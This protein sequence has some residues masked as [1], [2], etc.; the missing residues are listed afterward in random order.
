MQYAKGVPIAKGL[1]MQTNLGPSELPITPDGRIYHLNLLPEELADTVITVGDPDRVTMISK[2]F[3]RI[4]VQQQHREFVTH[5]GTLNNKRLSVISTGIG[6]S[7]ID[8]VMNELDA[9]ANIDF[10]TREYK[11]THR[12]LNII[13]IG[14]CG[15]LHDDIALG[16]YA[17][18]TAAIGLDGLLHFYECEYLLE[19][20]SLNEAVA[21]QL[22]AKNLPIKPYTAFASEKLCENVAPLCESGITTTCL[23]FYAPQNR[24]LRCDIQTNSLMEQLRDFTHNGQ[25]I[26]NFEMETAA[27]FGMGRLLQHQCSSISLIVANRFNNVFIDNPHTA[28]D[29]MIVGLLP[30][31]SDL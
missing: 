15:G 21:V 24:R 7:N 4:D 6:T 22:D 17:L 10:T 20:Q 29:K 30:V 8:I 5:T 23:G 28:M 1:T 19:E 27:I 12:E 2:H 25:R 31:I 3:D 16:S 14:T 18:S 11:K 26:I 13:R 9:L